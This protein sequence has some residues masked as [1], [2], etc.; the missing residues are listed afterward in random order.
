MTNSEPLW[1]M[2]ESFNMANPA[3]MD[4]LTQELTKVNAKN[5][6]N[7]PMDL[8][9]FSAI[10]QSVLH[11]G[12]NLGASLGMGETEYQALTALAAQTYQDGDYKKSLQIFQMAMF[13]D[14]FNPNNYFGC[15]ANYQKLKDYQRAVQFYALVNIL[16]ATN[17]N[18]A[19]HAGQCFVLLKKYNEAKMALEGAMGLTKDTDLRQKCQNLLDIIAK[20]TLH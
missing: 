9:Q 6:G 14:H 16:D 2:I 19:F 10:L 17:A 20:P 8:G 4:N 11:D 15:A 13:L 12:A 1:K 18:A 7:K 3:I 5:T